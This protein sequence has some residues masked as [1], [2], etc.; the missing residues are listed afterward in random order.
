MCGAAHLEK[1]KGYNRISCHYTIVRTIQT[2]EVTKLLAKSLFNK[3][4]HFPIV[5]SFVEEIKKEKYI[6]TNNW[7]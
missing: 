1:P 3:L 6:I 4:R 2:V 7:D 5:N